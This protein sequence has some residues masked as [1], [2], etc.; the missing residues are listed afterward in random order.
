MTFRNKSKLNRHVAP[1]ALLSALLVA[2]WASSAASG[3]DSDEAVSEPVQQRDVITVTATKR[4][5]TLQETPVAVSVVG[6]EAIERAEIQDLSDLSSLVPSLRV[7]QSTNSASTNFYIRG[8]GNGANAIGIEPSVGVFIDGVYRSR[9]ASTISDLPNLER[10]EVLRGPQTTLFGKNASAGVISVVTSEPEFERSGSFE[11]GVGNYDLRRARGYMT[12]PLTDTIAYGFGALINDRSGYAEDLESGEFFNERNRWAVRGD[13]L[14]RP[15]ETASFRLIADYDE[16]DEL[17][18]IGTNLVEGPQT[19]AII[20]GLGGNQVAEDPFSYQTY[21][22]F[23]PTNEIENYG[24]SLQGDFDLGFATLTSITSRRNSQTRSNFD[25]DSTSLD[26]LGPNIETNEIETFTQEVRLTSAPGDNRVDWLVGAFLFDETI[27]IANEL[28]LGSDWRDYIAAFAADPTLL[29]GIE[30][31]AGLPIGTLGAEGQGT[32]EEMSQRNSAL[33]V[34][35]TADFHLSDRLTATLGLNYTTD[36]KNVRIAIENTDAFSALNLDQ[37]GY[38]LTMQSL[39]AQQGINILD[40]ASVGPFVQANPQLYAQLQQTALGIAQSDNNPVGAFRA[41][42]VLP[43]TVD[44]PNSVE[45]GQSDDD[46]VSYT[47]RLSYDISN[48]LSVYG[49][50]ATGFKAT[51]WNLSRRSAPSAADYTPGNTIFDTVTQ[52]PVFITPPSPIRDSGLNATNLTSGTR[53]AGPEESEVFEIG[54]KGEFDTVQFAF[55]VFDQTIENF[56]TIVWTG[57][58]LALANAEQQSTTGVEIDVTW[59][60]IEPL[61]LGFAGTFMDPVFDEFTSFGDGVD[62]SGQN[63]AGVADTQWSI[64]GNYNFQVG[65]MPAFVRADWQHTAESPFFNDPDDAALI[66]GAG[67]TNAVDQLNASAGIMFANGFGVSIWGRNILEDESIIAA[68]PSLAQL[69]SISGYPVQPRTYGLT[70]R[71]RF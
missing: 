43:P 30:T 42:Q 68:F 10:V 17:C 24:V 69:E 15:H 28:R 31:F 7:V 52:Q 56:Q 26:M 5:Q 25:P 66:D 12:G 70:L 33:S 62:V 67:Y 39:L 50:Y 41:F 8:F 51:S 63:P 29:P 61:T 1:V 38:S 71:G 4:E 27:D 32:S 3:Q 55:T 14:Y 57:Q 22:N 6:A 40:P 53:F 2:P 35:G 49:S 9:A 48:S 18:C 65:N 58:A 46:N 60:P 36:E 23:A 47:A 64:T 37:I 19:G 11:V 34:F 45:N 13:L 21:T 20:R 54:V 16:I 59:N 44:F